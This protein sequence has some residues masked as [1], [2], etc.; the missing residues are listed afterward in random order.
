MILLIL[1][2]AISPFGLAIDLVIPL[3]P[4]GTII[5]SNFTNLSAEYQGI[6]ALFLSDERLPNPGSKQA[7]SVLTSRINYVF[8]QLLSNL[9][10]VNIAQNFLTSAYKFYTTC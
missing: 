3:N 2:L 8:L 5:P 9:V 6:D 10:Q 4:N 7:E 1:L